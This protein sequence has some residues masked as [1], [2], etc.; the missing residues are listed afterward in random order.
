MGNRV[1][2]MDSTYDQNKMEPAIQPFFA[3]VSRRYW[4]TNVEYH[5]TKRTNHGT[6]GPGQDIDHWI[7][8]KF[9]AIEPQKISTEDL[10]QMESVFCQ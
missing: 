2:E 6:T 9:W 5:L 10:R 4:A 7:G 8:L 1:S 3:G